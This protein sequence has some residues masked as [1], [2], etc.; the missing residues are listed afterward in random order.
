MKIKTAEYITSAVKPAQYPDGEKPE[1]AFAGRSNVGKSSLI[2]K[3]LNRKNLAKTSA[4]PGKTRTLNFYEI[5]NA[6]RFCDLPGYGYAAV[7]RGT[8]EQWSAMIEEY[9]NSRRNL[10]GVV[11]LVDLRHEPTKLDKLM[12][13]WLTHYNYPR[14]IIATKSDKISKGKRKQHLEKI[15]CALKLRSEDVFLQ[16]SAKSGEGRDEVWREIQALLQ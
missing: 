12:Y 3:L 15:K 10:R 14:I 8:K 5:N 11:H 16:F 6:F 9:L 2:N 4:K 1:I 13:E 7:S